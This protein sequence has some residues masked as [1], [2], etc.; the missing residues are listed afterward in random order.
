MLN[1]G[2]GDPYT[3]FARIAAMTAIVGGIIA[4][5]GGAFSGGGGAT[6][7]DAQIAAAKGAGTVL[8]DKDMPS[9][10]INK[11]YDLL[12]SIHAEEY[13]E[14]RGINSG[15][16]SLQSG[17]TDTVARSFQGGG[18]QSA[19]LSGASRLSSS[20]KNAEIAVMATQAIMAPMTLGI[21]LVASKIPI[22]GDAI[23]KVTDWI[24]GGLFGKISKNVI[25]TGIATGSTSVNSV[26]SGSGINA[27]RA[28]MVVTTKDSWFKTSYK[29]DLQLS[30]LDKKI[31]SSL[32][33]VFYNMGNTMLYLAKQLGG[34][35]ENKLRNY[36][37]PSISVD[38]KG[39]SGEDAS[40]S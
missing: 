11:T 8:G 28:D 29:Y 10:S 13:A 2:D 12:K 30:A 1:Q 17:I 6:V 25:A 7:S 14:L 4:A 26:L 9:D 18:M 31:S 34:D 35:F 20:A 40:K 22:L 15:I 39:L 36:I 32:D 19:D 5:A 24:A 38:L 33:N 27:Q 21:S 16:K 37:I 23:S 3:A